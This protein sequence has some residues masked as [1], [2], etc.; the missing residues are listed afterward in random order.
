MAS[1]FCEVVYE[2]CGPLSMM[3][4]P[5]AMSSQY[6]VWWLSA[7]M[8]A[9]CPFTAAASC[10]D[11]TPRPAWVDSEDQQITER[12]FIAAG[13]SSSGR[14]ELADRLS[15]AKQNATRNLAQLIQVDVKNSLTVE[16][17][18]K[19][20]GKNI[21]T[22]ANVQSLTQ[23]STNL[24]LQNVEETAKWID[25]KS[26]E[27]WLQ[28]RVDKKLVEAKRREGLTKELFK[29]FI[30]KL[31]LV[32]DGKAGL[33]MRHAALDVALDILP[34]ID[35][36]LIP[37]ASSPAYYGQLLKKLKQG[38][39][40]EVE[41]LAFAK[42]T[43]EA[44]SRTVAQA[45][46]ETSQPVRAKL[47]NEAARQY[48]SLLLRFPNGYAALFDAG[49]IEMKLGELEELRGD[50]C[51]A[52]NYYQQALDANIQG[53]RKA[54]AQKRA[55]GLV[56]SVADME[57]TR[58]RQYF[59]GRDIEV[60]CFQNVLGKSHSWQKACD[61]MNNKM[62]SI[63]AEAKINNTRLNAGQLAEAFAG[64]V[65]PD[66]GASGHMVVAQ[67]ASGKMERQREKGEPG[68]EYRFNGMIWTLIME[69]GKVVFTDRFQGITGW[70]PV[71]PEMVMDVLALN[72]MKRWQNK[73]TDFLNQGSG[74]PN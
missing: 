34:R 45:G 56:C 4:M 54:V 69:N 42:S 48:K 41:G 27:V 71:S 66:G 39:Q 21:L 15:S 53:E 8:T 16:Q 60:M 67:F 22:E 63:G 28:V 17:T 43:L 62:R 14:G 31:D 68:S 33:D 30:G 64:N 44:A 37:E 74:K 50:S 9:W 32:Q 13:V 6:L 35:F 7:A 73:F 51:G 23:T 24:S 46:E 11:D 5:K 29:T 70:N 38:V 49:T 55:E 36:A 25:P 10:G 19:Q 1:F 52:K 47:F 57:K 2:S 65:F 18:Q 20:L 61:E 59:E 3:H 40:E 72:V 12:Y 26:C 58:W